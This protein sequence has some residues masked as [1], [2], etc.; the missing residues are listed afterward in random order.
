MPTTLLINPLKIRV[1]QQSSAPRETNLLPPRSRSIRFF[2][3][4]DSAHGDGLV[5]FPDRNILSRKR[6]KEKAS[7][8]SQPK[9]ANRK[10]SRQR[11][12]SAQVSS[13]NPCVPLWLSFCS[14]RPTRG[15]LVSPRPACA[16]W[17]GGAIAPSGRPGSSCACES[18]ASSIACAGWVGMYAWA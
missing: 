8:R 9:K 15:N 2:L 6:K 13:V 1:A 14:A 16:P 18:H 5:E 10:K 11:R 17:R 7:R 4:S 3:G 12:S